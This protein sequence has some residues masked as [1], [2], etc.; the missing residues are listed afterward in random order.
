MLN[1]INAKD[2]SVGKLLVNSMNQSDYCQHLVFNAMAN[3]K[4]MVLFIYQGGSNQLVG[5]KVI[6]NNSS[7]ALLDAINNYLESK[8]HPVINAQEF[9][10]VK[11]TA[12]DFLNVYVRGYGLLGFVD[13]Q[14][15]G[16][17]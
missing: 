5:E 13:K 7:A 6:C 9:S 16:L 4:Q 14:P 11:S 2:I 15:P 10:I 1:T 12:T 17:V 8:D 3:R